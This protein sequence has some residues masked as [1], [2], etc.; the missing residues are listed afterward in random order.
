MET[1]VPLWLA[2]L[3]KKKSLCHIP[4]PSWIDASNLQSILKQEQTQ[5]S[6]STDLPYHALEVAHLLSTDIPAASTILLQDIFAVRQ[7]KIRKN[8]HTLA[9]QALSRPEPLPVV[10]VTGIAS[11]EVAKIAPFC[12]TAFRHHLMLLSKGVQQ[13]REEKKL[14]TAAQ[15]GGENSGSDDDRNRPPTI[16][17][18]S[19]VRRRFR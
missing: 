9:E 16:P 7:D 8:L 14:G 11:L 4:P 12:E 2:L 19:R 10:D 18:G 6:F 15:G 13:T 1:T 3:L 5:E 17:A